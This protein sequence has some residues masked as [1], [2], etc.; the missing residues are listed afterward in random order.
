M[1]AVRTEDGDAIREISPVPADRA[2]VAED[3]LV[4]LGSRAA[5]DALAP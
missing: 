3:R 4:L 2:F 5:L 1:L